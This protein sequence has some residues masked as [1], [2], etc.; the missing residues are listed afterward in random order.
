[1]RPNVRAKATTEV[2]ADWPRKDDTHWTWSGQAVAAVVGRRL[3]EG[4]GRSVVLVPLRAM[5]RKTRAV[6]PKIYFAGCKRKATFA[7]MRAMAGSRQIT[8]ND[9]IGR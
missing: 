7:A 2:D 8:S 3:S 4:L 5:A 1:V 9:A 6:A